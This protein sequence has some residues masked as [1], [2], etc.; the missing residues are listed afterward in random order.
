MKATLQDCLRL[1]INYR[2]Y[3]KI[4][5]GLECISYPFPTEEG[6]IAIMVRPENDPTAIRQVAIPESDWLRSDTRLVRY[7]FLLNERTDS[8]GRHLAMMDGWQQGD[9]LVL[10]H[11]G[12]VEVHRLA[13]PLEMAEELFRLFNIGYP[14]GYRNRSMSV[15]DVVVLMLESGPFGM[16]VQ[17]VGFAGVPSLAELRWDRSRGGVR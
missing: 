11:S 13:T 7:F 2:P 6:G 9:P 5:G 4:D 3:V 1:R 16:A 17:S 14:T 15:G 10:A 8:E 12:N